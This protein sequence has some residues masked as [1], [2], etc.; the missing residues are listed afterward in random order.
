MHLVNVVPTSLWNVRFVRL[1]IVDGAPA[2]AGRLCRG[3][4]VR[5]K[6]AVTYGRYSSADSSLRD[7]LLWQPATTATSRAADFLQSG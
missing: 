2:A 3:Y 6:S 7:S 5:S 4:S 1:A